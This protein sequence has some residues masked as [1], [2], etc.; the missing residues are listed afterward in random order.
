METDTTDIAKMN[1]A[2]RK[3]GVGI[4]VTQGVRMLADLP[5]LIDEIRRFRNFTP[6]NDPYGEHDFGSVIWE[7][8]KVLWKI[9]YY[10]QSLEHGEDPLSERC[11]RVMTVMLIGEY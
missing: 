8:K 7:G 11:R 10:D 6:G 5:G 2:F 9:D 1:D 4:V 3:S